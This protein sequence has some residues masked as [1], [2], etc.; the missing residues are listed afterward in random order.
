MVITFVGHSCLNNSP[1][2][3]EYIEKAIVSSVKDN[4]SVMFYCGGY[5]DF[6]NLCARVCRKLQ[7]RYKNCEIALIT[8]YITESHQKKLQA[9]QSA[10]KY[11]TIIYPPLEKVPPR[12]AISKRNEWMIEQADVV[13]AYVRN[14]YGGAR[15]TLKYAKR[16]K[17]VII[18]LADCDGI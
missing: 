15:Q 16:K 8:P 2:L 7:Y 5:G 11:D 9:L 12:F 1:R 6:D 3:T 18:N 13:I 4:G 14:S 10:H 17:K